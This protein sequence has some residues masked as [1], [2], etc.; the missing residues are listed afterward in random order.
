MEQWQIDAL[1]K[2]LEEAGISVNVADGRVYLHSSVY[3][4]TR[5][6]MVSRAYDG[7]VVIDQ[8]DMSE[9]YQQRVTLESQEVGPLLRALLLWYLERCKPEE[10]TEQVSSSE[11]DSL[12]N[13]DDHPF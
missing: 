13:L 8:I 9:K 5:Y 7:D 12:G 6:H 11:N 10:Q 1:M 4:D 2:L 3:G